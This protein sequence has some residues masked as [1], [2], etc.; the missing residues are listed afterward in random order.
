MISIIIPVYNRAG[1]IRECLESVFAQSY[2]DY[3]VIVVDDGST[4]KLSEA[5]LPYMNRIRYFNIA[6]CG[7]ACARNH[8]IRQA[9][10]EFIAWLDSDDRWLP[11]KLEIEKSILDKLP[12]NIG[13]IHS[14]FSCFTDDK[15]RIADSYIREYFFTLDTYKLTFDTLYSSKSTVRDMGITVKPVPPGARIYWGDVSDKVILGPLFLPSSMIIRRECLTAAGFFNES[16]RTGEDFDLFARVARKYE[17]AYLDFP[18]VDYRRFHADQLSSARME[19][20]TNK[21]YLKVVMDLGLND[22]NYCRDNAAF[23]NMR[24]SHAHYGLGL[25]YYKRKQYYQA[26]KEFLASVKIHFRQKKIYLF[27]IAAFV[28]SA[29]NV[30][31]KWRKTDERA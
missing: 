1:L 6:N 17:V 18:T 19:L 3:E 13:F 7:A 25:A 20:E 30:M 8:G 2:K 26:L 29:G 9:Q 21:A 11:F 24:L 4:D 27:I 5:L 23:V 14:D 12:R 15:G 10:G 28:R 31:S 22:N 16:M